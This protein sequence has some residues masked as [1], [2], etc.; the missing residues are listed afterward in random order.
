MVSVILF[1]SI[2]FHTD[3]QEE[4]V[5]VLNNGRKLIGQVV[6]KDKSSIIFKRKGVT[7][8]IKFSDIRLIKKRKMLPEK[9]VGP[10][11]KTKEAE[12]DKKPAQHTKVKKVTDDELFALIKKASVSDEGVEELI[13]TLG[14]NLVSTLKKNIKSPSDEEAK[15]VIRLIV[16]VKDKTREENLWLWFLSFAKGKEL[17]EGF[18]VLESTKDAFEGF[19]I[20]V[21]AL[22][23]SEKDTVIHFKKSIDKLL[24][25]L[26]K[27]KE[28]L[29][30]VKKFLVSRSYAAEVDKRVL[31]F[32]IFERNFPKFSQNEWKLFITHTTL[33]VR[34]KALIFAIHSNFKKIDKDILNNLYSDS[35]NINE[36]IMILKYMDRIPVFINNADNKYLYILYQDAL[37]KNDGKGREKALS[38]SA[39]RR[40][41]K[42]SEKSWPVKDKE[43]LKFFGKD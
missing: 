10:E 22:V 32:D 41:K 18:A 16:K 38:N 23:Y 28:K 30:E 9:V 12:T 15:L 31:I 17:A 4:Y 11:E 29:K 25:T 7:Q 13:K 14:D 3:L 5:V 26:K 39:Y 37:I 33:E 34:M 36:K 24:L 19:R 8:R 2:F 42:D 43:W 40:L 21:L 6:E 20:A 27:D 35:K 1:L